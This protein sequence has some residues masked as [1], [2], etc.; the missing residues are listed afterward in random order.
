MEDRE[1]A[2]ERSRDADPK[3][4]RD[5]VAEFLLEKANN[6]CDSVKLDDGAPLLE[7]NY[8]V[9]VACR[10]LR[11]KF[12]VVVEESEAV[13]MEPDEFRKLAHKKTLEGYLE[14]EA[15]FPVLAGLTY[16]TI[17]DQNGKRYDCE[18]AAAWRRGASAPRWIAQI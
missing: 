18:G 8:G 5:S 3:A 15:R 17:H 2:G 16:F 13:K 14:R 1:R 4:Y 6:F 11:D 10:W 12:G 7:E 9:R